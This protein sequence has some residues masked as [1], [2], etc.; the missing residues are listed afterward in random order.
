M[1]HWRYVDGC[2]VFMRIYFLIEVFRYSTP[3][4]LVLA[5]TQEHRVA[6]GVLDV[7]PLRGSFRDIC[8]IFTAY[9]PHLARESTTSLLYLHCISTASPSQFHDIYNLK[10]LHFF[11]SQR[12]SKY[13]PLSLSPNNMLPILII[14]LPQ[15]NAIL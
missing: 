13:Q 9:I 11:I 14:L 8:R 4:G 6:P 1:G 7:E 5:G 15:S 12:L 10:E 2:W 3:S